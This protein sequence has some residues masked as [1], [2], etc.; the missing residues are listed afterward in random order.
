MINI[1]KEIKSILDHWDTPSDAGQEEAVKDIKE[2]FQALLKERIESIRTKFHYTETDDYVFG[3][4]DK[5]YYLDKKDF[6]QLFKKYGIEVIS[7][8]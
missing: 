5:Y 4:V 2:L 7:K 8:S 3:T 6:D 1:D